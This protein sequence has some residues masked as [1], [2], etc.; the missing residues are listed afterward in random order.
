MTLD[1][2]VHKTLAELGMTDAA[3]VEG[4]FAEVRAAIETERA[5]L[6]ARG[7]S[8][9]A[10]REKLCKVF[11]DRWLARKNGLLSLV[12]ENWLK[13]SAKDLKPSVGRLINGLR[14]V[15]ATLET[16]AVVKD[17]PLKASG[18]EESAKDSPSVSVSQVTR[19]VP[20]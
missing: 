3:A 6:V 18:G 9:E 19:E 8:S 2:K 12:D 11:R 14:Q 7:A 4:L 16:A 10:E 13:A 15:S 17:V 5:A 20:S 1:E